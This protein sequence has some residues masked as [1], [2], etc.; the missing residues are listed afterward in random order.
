MKKFMG[1]K[2]VKSILL[3]TLGQEVKGIGFR[4]AYIHIKLQTNCDALFLEKI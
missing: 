2:N 3:V 4:E 1:I